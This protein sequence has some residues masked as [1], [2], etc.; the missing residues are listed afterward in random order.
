MNH[1][2]PFFILANPRSGSSLL[3]IVCDCNEYLT[4][5]PESGFLLWWGKKYKD[6]SEAE[7]SQSKILNELVDDILSS[8]KFETW[9]IEKE[10]LLNFLRLHHPK[11]YADAGSL[12]Y[13]FQ[14]KKRGKSPKI[15]G[16]KNNY[17]IHHL[18]E[19]I[20][21]YPKAKFIHLVRDGRDVACSYRNL[22]SIASKSDYF[23]NLTVDLVEIAREWA[24]NNL[25]ID[26]F[27]KQKAQGNFLVLA[28]EDV[29]LSLEETSRKISDFLGV[30][31]DKNMLE[32]DVLNRKNNLEPSQT[33]DWK[34]NTLKKPDK[35]RINQYMDQFTKEQIELFTKEAGTVLKKYGYV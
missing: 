5:P 35:S 11:S 31:F 33:L 29:V 22:P 3:R 17:Y 12:V 18:Q 20:E 21:L 10:E 28:Y 14:A 25:R 27:L 32:Y 2:S 15:W 8:K 16:D 9:Q 1:R 34:M 30:P 19:I 13:Y 4:V 6:I 26:A 7:L 23:P 24:T